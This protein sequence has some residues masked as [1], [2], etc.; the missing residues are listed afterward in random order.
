MPAEKLKTGWTQSEMQAKGVEQSYTKGKVG[1]LG[2]ARAKAANGK[3]RKG[4]KNG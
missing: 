1:T 2:R 3:I 4:Y